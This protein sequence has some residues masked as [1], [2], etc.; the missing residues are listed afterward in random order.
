M[1]ITSSAGAGITITSPAKNNGTLSSS[2]STTIVFPN[3]I[4]TNNGNLAISPTLAGRLVTIRPGASNEETRYMLS[5]NGST[6][7]TISEAWEIPPTGGESYKVSYIIQDVA[8]VNGLALINKRT[9]DY[10]SSRRLT[11]ASTGFLALLNGAS[12]ETVGNASA[13]VADMIVESGGRFDNGYLNANRGVAGGS[14]FGAGGAGTA[15]GNLVFDAQAGS[16]VRVYDLLFKSVNVYAQKY[17][18]KGDFQRAKF[19][20]SNYTLDLTGDN[21]L[22]DCIIEGVG[23]AGIETIQVDS[24]TNINSLN[25]VS[26]S[27]FI[28]VDNSVE[29]RITLKDVRF[30]GNKK[31]AY[32][33]DNK[34]WRF[35]NPTWSIDTNTQNEIQF[36]NG[37]NNDAYEQ[38]SFES[39]ISLVDGTLVS[40]AS[41]Q[42][43]ESGGNLIRHNGFSNI[44]GIYNVDITKRKF[45]N[46]AGTSLNVDS[47]T[48]FYLKVYDFG[49]QPAL[50]P[51]SVNEAMI[52]TLTLPPDTSVNSSSQSSAIFDGPSGYKIPRYE[53]VTNSDAAYVVAYDGAQGGAPSIGST[54]TDGNFNFGTLYDYEGDD[55]QGILV[56]INHNGAAWGNNISIYEQGGEFT[57]TVN[58]SGVGSVSLYYSIILD[59]FNSTIN[60]MYDAISAKFANYRSPITI[61]DAYNTLVD[62]S[63][64]IA[65]GDVLPI[66]ITPSGGWVGNSGSIIFGAVAPFYSLAFSYSASLSPTITNWQYYGGD[67]WYDLSFSDET[68]SFGTPS[69]PSFPY[70]YVRWESPSGANPSWSPTIQ[71]GIPI[72]TVRSL[73]TENTN[74]SLIFNRIF[75]EKEYE[76]LVIWGAGQRALPLSLGLNGWETY[77]VN[78]QGVW[79]ANRGAGTVAFM[80]ANDGTQYTPPSQYTFTLTGLKPN[81]EVRIYTDTATPVEIGGTENS[82]TSFTYNFQYRGSDVDIYVVVH[83]VDY[84]YIRINNL[85]LSNSNQSVPIS[86]RPDRNFLNP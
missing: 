20:S 55:S 8:T 66:S 41:Y 51:L 65:S 50:L 57:A 37:T 60:S 71:D 63:N 33:N 83:H 34:H 70:K 84:E 86:Q 47:R 43:Y 53:G 12:L 19:F 46:N 73:F 40:G 23:G 24:N 59:C 64:V 22:R 2:T 79:L 29:E 75:V 76:D 28:G 9:N 56:L 3:S 5:D 42:I 74:G 68:D 10:S 7:A 48:G 81:S 11:V 17:N 77:R 78:S 36:E 61:R 82:S 27:G 67:G 52:Q 72:Y 1:A 21:S 80:T 13:S 54:I 25:V 18:G 49:Y 6:T 62:F 85:T 32:I 16:D 26:T 31:I 4:A 45:T 38:F 44:S 58:S 39:S 69:T 14:I 35:V 30:I 15:N